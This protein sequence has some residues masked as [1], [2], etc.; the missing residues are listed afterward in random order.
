[1]RSGIPALKTRT[2]A[3][4]RW[5]LARRLRGWTRRHRLGIGDASGN[6]AVDFALVLPFFIALVIGLIEIGRVLYTDHTLDHAAREGVRYAIVR[7]ANSPTPALSSDIVTVV[8]SRATPLD[9]AKVG[10]AV[11]FDPNNRPG[12]AVAVQVTYFY[13]FLMPVPFGPINLASAARMTIVN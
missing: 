12:S 2:E 4:G 9:P 11:S 5:L 13:E 7:G 1:M 6:A 10:V 3:P 8:K